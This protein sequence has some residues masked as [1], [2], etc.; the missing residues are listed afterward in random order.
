MTNKTRISLTIRPEL[1]SLLD[2]KVD[3]STIQNRSHAIEYFIKK[4]LLNE[5]RQA[6]IFA[7]EDS[8]QVIK[9]K[10]VLESQLELLKL[11]GIPNIL[12]CHKQDDPSKL[13][14]IV[15]DKSIKFVA[16]EQK[17]TAHALR[18]CKPHILPGPFL[19]IYGDVLSK[20]DL[21]DFFD[22]HKSH[23]KS[24][25]ICVTSVL[26]P[27]PWGVI[28]LKRNK[29]TSFQEKPDKTSAHT[30]L[31]NAGIFIFEPT[32]FYDIDKNTKS[33]EK[34]VLPILAK[35]QELFG[36]FLDGMWFDVGIK[37]FKE[38]AQNKWH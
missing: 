36:Y 2:S 24:A 17:G 3:G 20:I 33:L 37:E 7:N 32:I 8:L 23:S 30:H 13:K 25:S 9:G 18:N 6:I 15:K 28:R 11:Y 5:L 35:R 27:K 38:L 4:A 34:E 14:K 12:I 21:H 1:L 29:V 19:L 31:I 26:D 10:T 22:F 16:G